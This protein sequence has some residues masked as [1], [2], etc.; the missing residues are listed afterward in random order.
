MALQNSVVALLVQGASYSVQ[1]FDSGSSKRAPDHHASSSMFDSWCHTEEPSY[2]LLDGVQKPYVMN[3]WFQILIH[4]SIRHEFQFSVVHWQCF[5]AQ[6]S[7]F[8][9]FCHLS[10]GFLI[11]TR[12]VKPAA[13]SLLFT[14]ETESSLL[15]PVLSCA[16]SC[17]TVSRRSRK[18][19]TFRN[20]S[21]DCFMALVDGGHLGFWD[22]DVCLWINLFLWPEGTSMPKGTFASWFEVNT[23]FCALNM[24]IIMGKYEKIRFN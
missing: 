21:S 7:L 12:P 24:S 9:L 16:W 3:R 13:R 20:L 10:N 22:Y 4:R 17:C 8:F 15:R 5:M 14:V 19:L 2:R 1:V 11:A 6:A 18:L 23:L